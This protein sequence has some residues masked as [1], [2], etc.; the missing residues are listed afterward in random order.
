MNK[1]RRDDI[2]QVLLEKNNLL[3]A[4]C[5]LCQEQPPIHTYHWVSLENNLL[6]AS[7][8]LSEFYYSQEEKERN[9]KVS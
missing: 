5:F 3:T 1:S 2:P 7:F 6:T 4:P 8:L 9:G